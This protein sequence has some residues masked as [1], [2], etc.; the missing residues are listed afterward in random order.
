MKRKITIT[1]T[2]L[3]MLFA[4][5]AVAEAQPAS[6]PQG[7]TASVLYIAPD[8]Q[9]LATED[10]FFP[11]GMTT[12]YANP[13]LIPQGY[14]LSGAAYVQVIVTAVD[15][16]I[17]PIVFTI[18]PIAVPETQAA[19]VVVTH[20]PAPLPSVQVGDRVAFGHYEQDN[21]LNNGNEPIQWRVLEVRWPHVLLLSEH[22]LD[23][24]PY[25]DQNQPVTW[26][27]S[28]MRTWMNGP[29]LR[30]MAT[31]SEAAFIVPAELSNPANYHTGT[32]SGMPTTDS[33]FLLSIEEAEHYLRSAADRRCANTPY[34]NAKGA[35]TKGGYGTWW[36]RTAGSYEKNAAVVT[37]SGEIGYNGNYMRD[38]VYTVRPALWVDWAGYQSLPSK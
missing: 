38:K 25:H 14:V 16:Q 28:A 2:I 35:Q 5:G 3:L 20:Q 19:P 26:E 9:V 37:E 17:N 31:D 27:W 18:A 7:V 6:K 1:L 32:Y 29:F 30:Q 15:K 12:Y 21:N 23:C 36:L 33:I 22:A 13:A 10:V 11:V 34:A 4:T 8:K 24:R